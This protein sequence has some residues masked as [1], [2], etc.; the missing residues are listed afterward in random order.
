MGDPRHP[1]TAAPARA[2][3]QRISRNGNPVPGL[4]SQPGANWPCTE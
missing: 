3:H 2:E 1:G 4:I